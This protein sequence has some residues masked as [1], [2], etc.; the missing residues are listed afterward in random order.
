MQN[1]THFNLEGCNSTGQALDLLSRD[2]QFESHKPQG[3]W[4]FTWWLILGSV[5]LIEVRTSWSEHS[6]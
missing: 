1:S 6:R 5:R 2:H 4:R 3:H